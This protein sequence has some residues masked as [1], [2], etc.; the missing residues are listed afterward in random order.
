MVI[1]AGLTVIWIHRKE[2]ARTEIKSYETGDS[3]KEVINMAG[4]TSSQKRMSKDWNKVIWDRMSV[5][6][7]GHYDRC[8][9]HW[10]AYTEMGKMARLT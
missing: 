2:W 1:I 6:R 7:G 3:F 5:N 4:L 9:L 8:S 10:I